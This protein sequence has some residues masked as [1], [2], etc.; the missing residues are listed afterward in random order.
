[1]NYL[2]LFQFLLERRDQQILDAAGQKEEKKN[3]TSPDTTGIFIKSLGQL[4]LPARQINVLLITANTLCISDVQQTLKVVYKNA[5]LC[6]L[7]SVPNHS[8]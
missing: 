5:I 1:M 3:A 4:L 2:P 8:T 6:C 7:Q